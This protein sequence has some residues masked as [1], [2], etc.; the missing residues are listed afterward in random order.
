MIKFLMQSWN[1]KERIL[2]KILVLQ[3]MWPHLSASDVT[4]AHFSDSIAESKI[5]AI[6]KIPRNYC[7]LFIM[8]NLVFNWLSAQNINCFVQSF[9]LLKNGFNNPPNWNKNSK[10]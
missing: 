1:K 6:A 2:S 10:F 5:D 7:R 3:L 8:Y 4:G 9:M